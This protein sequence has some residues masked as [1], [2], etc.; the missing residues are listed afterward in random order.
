M[1]KKIY[2][3]KKLFLCFIYYGG[4]VANQIFWK[5]LVKLKTESRYKT[6]SS[7]QNY[8]YSKFIHFHKVIILHTL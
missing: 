4:W 2:F 6:N 1:P 3:R 7:A 5:I 8:A